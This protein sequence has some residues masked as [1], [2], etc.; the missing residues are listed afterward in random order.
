MSTRAK[1]WLFMIAQW[2]LLAAFVAAVCFA[3]IEFSFSVRSLAGAVILLAGIVVGSAALWAHWRR[4]GSILVKPSP[5]PRARDE[6]VTEGVYRY[7]RHPIY[8]SVMLMLFGVA[9]FVWNWVALMLAVIV[10]VFYGIKLRFEEGL[11]LQAYPQY[12]EYRRVT[13]ALAP[14]VRG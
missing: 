10:A 8:L 6:L 3:P 5:E 7:V 4:N 14:R 12:A 1:I 13:G 11:L 2:I 9:L